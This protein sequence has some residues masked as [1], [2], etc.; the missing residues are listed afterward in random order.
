MLNKERTMSLCFPSEIMF[1]IKRKSKKSSLGFVIRH[2]SPIFLKIN[3]S[4][5]YRN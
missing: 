5:L 2:N 3:S 4:I 1:F